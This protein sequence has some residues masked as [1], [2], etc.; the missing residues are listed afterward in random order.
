MGSKVEH[1]YYGYRE[2][3]IHFFCPLCKEHKSTKIPQKINWRHHASLAILTTVFTYVAYPIFELKGAFLY[4]F[5]WTLLEFG[6]RAKKREA[7]ICKSCGFDP[8]LYKTDVKRARNAL[9]KHWQVK[10]EKENLFQ[11]IKLK[12]YETKPKE[13]AQAPQLDTTK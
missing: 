10:I 9:R 5:F 11:G 7:L 1:S 6:V 8:F 12:N 3:R 4:F 13:E 2:G